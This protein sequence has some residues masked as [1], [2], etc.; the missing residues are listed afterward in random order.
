MLESMQIYMPKANGQ[1]AEIKPVAVA[2][3][4]EY[5]RKPLPP[6]DEEL[7]ARFGAAYSVEIGRR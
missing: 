6:V 4:R 7:N 5:T 2:K 1:L 3:Q